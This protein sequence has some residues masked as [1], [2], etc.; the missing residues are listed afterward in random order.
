MSQW[1][2]YKYYCYACIYTATSIP[3][4]FEHAKSKHNVEHFVQLQYKCFDCQNIFIHYSSFLNHIRLRHHPALKLRCDACDI[5]CKTFQEYENHR[6]N[7]CT[8]A[9][10]YPEVLPCKFC[11]KNFHTSCGL[12]THFKQAHTMA[13]EEAGA[14]I[15]KCQQ[16]NKTFSWEK[17]LKNHE[18]THARRFN[19]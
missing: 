9:L 17:G 5:L 1:K 4:L 13:A 3:D 10:L 19:R 7:A 8:Q 18:V 6:K 14:K 15:F 16:C 12:Q 11:C 2:S